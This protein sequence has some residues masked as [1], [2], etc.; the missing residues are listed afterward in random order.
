M[1]EGLTWKYGT[2][3][4]KNMGS[5]NPERGGLTGKKW[6]GPTRKFGKEWPQKV[7][8]Y[9]SKNEKD[10]TKKVGIADF[11]SYKDWLEKWE[12]LTLNMEGL[13]QNKEVT[14]TRIATVQ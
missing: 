3:W 8:R 7:E 9:G 11:K 4:L 10:W 12:G 6:E 2:L 13:C 14:S 1:W 5:S